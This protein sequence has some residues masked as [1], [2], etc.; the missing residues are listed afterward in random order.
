MQTHEHIMKL[1]T[2]LAFVLNATIIGFGAYLYADV[3]R[4]EKLKQEQAEL[5]ALQV[6]EQARLNAEAAEREKQVQ[7]LAM[8]VY[9]EAR[10]EGEL[11]QRAVAW[12]T[13]NRVSH[14]DYPDTVCDV[15]YEAV[16]DDSGNPIRDKCQFS[17]FCD[18]KS[19][20]IKDFIAWLEAQYVASD[21]MNKYGK[22][23]DPTGGAIMYHADYV[24]PFWVDAYE[25]QVEI[26]THI[27]Y[28]EVE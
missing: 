15:V 19:D 10:N 22:E 12:A 11:G 14:P 18:G 3:I 21:V 16:T 13:L 5:I 20:E 6:L 1:R 7:C 24:N 9:H 4:T 8:N 26:D 23:T 25:R 2:K 27:F 17:W 28:A